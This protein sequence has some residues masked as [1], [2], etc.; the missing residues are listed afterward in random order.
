MFANLS[1]IKIC[2][3]CLSLIAQLVNAQ[4][5]GYNEAFLVNSYTTGIQWNPVIC[6]LSDSGFVICWE[7]MFQDGDEWGIF[8]QIFDKYRNKIGEE[9]QVNTSNPYE[10]NEPTISVLSDGG[11]V[12]CWE[13]AG[14]DGD[15]RGI[16]G[17]IFEANGMKR[18]EEFQV[19]TYS[20][21][22]QVNPSVIGLSTGGFVVCWM[23]ED[24]TYD[25]G[26]YGQIFDHSGTKIGTELHIET[27]TWA[28]QRD[29]KVTGLSDG[30]F[31]VCWVTYHTSSDG[32]I[33]ARIYNNNGSPRTDEFLV[34]AQT[35]GAQHSPAICRLAE[36]RFAIFWET[37]YTSIIGKIYKA[38]GSVYKSDF[39]AI[40]TDGR[41]PIVC[42]LSE[43]GFV[44]CWFGPSITHQPGYDVFGQIFQDD[45]SIEED[46]FA[47][48]SYAGAA[49]ICG[50]NSGDILF[51]WSSGD[52]GDI[53]AKYY[54]RNPIDHNL[55]T[56]E[57][58]S[59]PHGH[60]VND[61]QL[62]FSWRAASQLPINFTYEINYT[63]FIDTS[64]IFTNPQVYTPIYD[65]TC[66]IS[67]LGREESYY[68]KVMAQNLERDS[69]W[70]SDTFGFYLSTANQLSEIGIH[71][72]PQFT[73]HQNYPNPFNPETL[74]R[75]YLPSH[76]FVTISIYDL[77]GR[78]IY[79]LVKGQKT[80]GA[81]QVT[82]SGQN[83]SGEK[84]SSGIYYYVMQAGPFSETK[85]M[86]LIK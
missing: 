12:I 84:V 83:L 16:F 60:T 21:Q 7:S 32:D 1:R 11:F 27:N 61:T 86:I 13:S 20:D 73:L 67:D 64:Q 48:Y 22:W 76:Q 33:S 53:H 50:L 63:L 3:L 44:L 82:W 41:E 31:V 43:G 66:T 8:G 2:I 5:T 45:G 47:T 36:D 29:A 37:Q 59:P 52:D 80:A 55:D 30:G 26:I 39:P 40:K 28:M 15:G 56:F 70:S 18:G 4:E 81:H 69:M 49:S 38:D 35:D 24:D 65:T 42:N 25:W 62:E 85:K 17:Q 54:L 57:L 72:T 58:L 9:F 23:G 34:N 78:L 10:Q 75:Y 51:S 14:Q 46:A 68:W 79:V 6:S 77:R 71:I 19:N 74:I